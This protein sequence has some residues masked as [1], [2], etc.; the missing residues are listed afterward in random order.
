MCPTSVAGSAEALT[1][2]I[3]REDEFA[4]ALT[5]ER[6]RSERSN[7]PFLLLLVHGG[8]RFSRTSS[9]RLGD[10]VARRLR[11]AVR[12]TDLVGWYEES[13][14]VGVILTEICSPVAAAESAVDGKIREAIR[15][16]G[17]GTEA[18]ITIH[19]F[20]SPGD[21]P[22]GALPDD[23][24]FY[25]EIRI[26][27]NKN[28]PTLRAKR[29]LDIVASATALLVLLPLM[30]SIAAL[31][32]LTSRGPALFRQTRVGRLGCPFQLLKFRSMY[33][34]N[35]SAQHRVYLANMISGHADPHTDERGR[36]LFKIV[37]DRRVTPLG[38]VLRRLSLDELPQLLNVLR[39]EMSLVGPRPP[40]PYEVAQY[41][42]WQRRRLMLAKPGITGLWQ[43]SGR[44]RLSYTEMVRL[45]IAYLNRI[46]V[47]Q[48]L[49]I[50]LRTP[51]AVFGG[52]G[53]A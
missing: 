18:E 28:A 36:P 7:R 26:A 32:R 12:E 33:A 6:K 40:L 8:S 44:C 30:V 42:T 35:D 25:P 39:G 5:Q 43:V 22:S 11:M 31:V 48:D 21:G 34:D 52:E 51:R 13:G 46:S 50:L 4:Q 29:A 1:A 49:R 15:E 20:P 37:G 2:R 3:L 19:Q 41:R 16:S 47:V 45:D 14:T 53:A 17:G 24:I 10:R 27:G 38:R 23:A 9:S